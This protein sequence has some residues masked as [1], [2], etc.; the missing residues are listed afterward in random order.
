MRH[1]PVLE[2]IPS[3]QT[4]RSGWQGR[5]HFPVTD[6]LMDTRCS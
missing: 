4:G 1:T 3:F 6:G 2:A 5:N